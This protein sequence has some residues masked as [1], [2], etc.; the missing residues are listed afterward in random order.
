MGRTGPNTTASKF[1]ASVIASTKLY[2]NLTNMAWPT[3][4][5]EYLATIFAS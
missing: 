4:L 3:L 2:N 1:E 5:Y